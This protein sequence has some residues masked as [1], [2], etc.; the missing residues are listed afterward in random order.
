MIFHAPNGQTAPPTVASAMYDHAFYGRTFQAQ[1]AEGPPV[2][3]ELEGVAGDS[4]EPKPPAVNVLE[5]Y[6]WTDPQLQRQFIRLEQKFLA[7]KAT[8]EEA[9]EY[10][11]MKRDRNGSIFAERQVRDYAEIQR[12][13]KLAAKLAEVQKYLRP[14]EF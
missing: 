12:L 9:A 6:N 2:E 10:Q 13:R 7:K 11:A 8:R 5:D 3:T 4:F 1:A 14:L